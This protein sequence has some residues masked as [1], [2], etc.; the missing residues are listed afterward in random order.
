MPS[1]VRARR[2]NHIWHIL[3]ERQG[4]R[5]LELLGPLVEGDPE[6]GELRFLLAR[7]NRR[8]RRLE[9]AAEA[10]KRAESLGFPASRARREWVLALAQSGRMSEAEPELARMLLDPGDDGPEICEAFVSGYFVNY[11]I[12]KALRLLEGWEQDYP[13]DP[14]PHVLRGKYFEQLGLWDK[15][16]HEYRLALELAPQA[17]EVRESLAQTLVERHEY[18]TALAEF[19]KCLAGNAEHLRA[20]LGKA[21]CLH[22]TRDDEAA[23]QALEEVL[24]HDPA[25]A[26]AAAMLG[27]IEFHSGNLEG[28]VARLSEAVDRKPRNPDY[29]FALAKALQASGEGDA[30]REHYHYVDRARVAEGQM[31]N[32]INALVAPD[33]RLQPKETLP[34]RLEVA[35]LALEFGEPNDAIGWLQSALQ[36][37]P[38]CGA[39]HRMLAE[40]YSSAGNTAQAAEHRRKADL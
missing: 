1:V 33:S 26:P 37:D 12:D 18:Q 30:A 8:V 11:E 13:R 32:T 20:L 19:E 7:A 2:V 5:A 35:R 22:E 29:R 24:K 36:I 3:A 34:L 38:R 10:L 27:D 28:A 17:A 16:S 25:S 15:A 6:S 4:E 21:R 14:Q 23:R 39:A 31:Q 40:Y 9:Q